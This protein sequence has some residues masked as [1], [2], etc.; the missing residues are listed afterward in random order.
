ML[1]LGSVLLHTLGIVQF[2]EAVRRR[3]GILRVSN[4]RDRF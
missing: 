1:A 4:G 2:V 3:V